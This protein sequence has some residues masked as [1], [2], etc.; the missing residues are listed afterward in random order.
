[1]IFERS[2]LNLPKLQRFLWCSVAAGLL[3]P[4][5]GAADVVT[6]H[7]LDGG[8]ETGELADW[9]HASLQLKTDKGTQ[10]I[11][12]EDLLDVKFQRPQ[13][14]ANAPQAFVELVDG[15]VIPLSQFTS[16]LGRAK[17]E[18][19]LSPRPLKLPLDTVSKLQFPSTETDVP[20]WRS[21]W[22][23]MNV[24]S[25]TLVVLKKHG[26][27]IDILDG[28]VG[29]VTLEH[30][31]FTW[32]G[33]SLEVKRSKL[34]GLTYY[35]ARQKDL[36]QPVCLFRLTGN[37]VLPARSF[38][39]LDDAVSIST[40]LGINF[41]LPLGLVMYADF[42]AGKLT[43]LS[44]L[45]PL[46]ER[47]T[48]LVRLPLEKELLQEYGRVRR[49]ESFAGEPLMLQWPATEGVFSPS[50]RTY[51]R[52][53]A[54][55]SRTVLEYRLPAGAKTFLATAGIDPATTMQGS[56][57]LQIALDD[58]VEFDAEIEGQEAPQEI[59]LDVTGKRRCRIL[60]DY[61]RNQDLGDRLHLVDARFTN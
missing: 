8:V 23:E 37:F 42:S 14:E 17:V 6:V 33:E 7:K 3:R 30:V 11:S 22:E 10:E 27:E 52:G 58:K 50:I 24:P 9:N 41:K 59:Q 32:G 21:K 18:S 28:V 12:S 39:L 56:V 16:K 55:R 2:N 49:D 43:F 19:E 36:R 26:T 15:T 51:S 25:D 29:D 5:A 60:V 45:E 47:W 35:R 48:P 61:G 4:V 54:L 40:P 57:R 31:T 20:E 46:R 13:P 53:L 1:M 38:R 44:A 34:A